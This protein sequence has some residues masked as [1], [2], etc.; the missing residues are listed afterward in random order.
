MPGSEPRQRRP[1]WRAERPA[2]RAGL[3]EVV[4]VADVVSLAARRAGEDHPGP[5]SA[6]QRFLAAVAADLMVSLAASGVPITAELRVGCVLADL[7][8]LGGV[9]LPAPLRAM[10]E[11]CPAVEL[12]P[13]LSEPDGFARL[14]RVVGARAPDWSD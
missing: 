1:A 3:G 8:D 9:P 10:V 7:L 2:S 11:A 5:G 6:E 12:P 13:S 4:I 14:L